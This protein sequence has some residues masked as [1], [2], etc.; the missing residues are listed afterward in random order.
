MAYA[1]LDI[2]DATGA[3]RFTAF[4]VDPNDR[5]VITR[6]AALLGDGNAKVFNVRGGNVLAVMDELLAVA[7]RQDEFLNGQPIKTLAGNRQA[8]TLGTGEL[9]TLSTKLADGVTRSESGVIVVAFEVADS[10]LNQSC[11]ITFY[12]CD[13][14]WYNV[15]TA[16]QATLVVA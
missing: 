13:K 12:P 3:T 7:I 16:T 11:V 1:T 9:V 5:Q 15:G 8:A 14:L 2:S 6:A 4:S 10:A